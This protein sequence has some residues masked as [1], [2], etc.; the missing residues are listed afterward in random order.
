MHELPT[1]TVTLLFTDI[2]GSTRLLEQ[3]GDGYA[4]AL[5]Q[6]RRLLRA[7]F[8]RHD[9]VEV[10]TQGDAFFVAFGTASDA[11]A[12]A[13]AARMAVAAAGPIRV[14]IGIH[15]GEPTRTDDGYIGMDVNRAARIAAAGHG[16]Q[17]LL[18]QSTRQL[19]DDTD[20]LDLGQHRLKD[21]GALRLFQV[22]DEQFPP[23]KSLGTA[24]LP[25]TATPLFGRQQELADLLRML[26]TERNVLVTI[27]GTGGIGKTRL[28]LEAAAELAPAFADGISFIDLSAVRE[29]ELVEP[30]IVG[31]LGLRGQ[32]VDH[33]RE[34]ELLLVLDNLEQVVQV[35]ANLAALLEASPRLA[36]LAT[37][38]EPLR[39]RAEVTYPLKPLAEAPAVELFR[40]RARMIEPEFDA[41]YERLTEL[42]ERLERI[43]LA[44]EL[45]AA[46]VKVLSPDDLLLR[47]GRRLP[48]LTAGARDAPTRQRTLRATI[49][50]SYELLD[51]DERG[52][53]MNLGVFVGGWTLDAAEQV[54]NADLDVLQ[55]LADKS[56]IRSEDGRFRML[57]TLREYALERLEESDELEPLRMRHTE[58]FLRLGLRAEPELTGAQQHVWLE[59]L[60]I[61]YENLRAALEWSTATQPAD[62]LRLASALV[63][64][65]FNRSLYR[66]G[67]HWLEEVLEGPESQASVARAAA[68]W[69]DGMLWA[70]VG[71]AERAKPR[72]ESGLALA[73]EL[74]APA[75]VARTLEVMG[76]LAFFQND[77]RGAR[78]LLEE[79]AE[80]ARLAGDMWALADAL[81]TL[82]SIYPLQG[83]FD[84]AEKVGAEARAIGREWGD[85][86]GIRM[87]N[88]GLALT[89][90]MRGNLEDARTLSEEG[91]A[92][93]R[94][95]GDLWFVSY[96]LWVL[97]TTATIAGEVRAARVLADESLKIARELEGPLL[98]VCAL[99]A[100]AAVDR[101]EGD[102]ASAQGHLLEALELGRRTI[103][104]DAYL[105]SV[106]RGLGELAVAAG[107][108]DAADA[109]LE[110]S[111]A[112]ARG[113][114]DVWG[115][116][117]AQASQAM[118]AARRGEHDAAVSLA[119]EALAIQERIGDELG[120]ADTSNRIATLTS[121]AR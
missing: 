70:L 21:V 76:L 95:I 36:I 111:I 69:G 25:R 104:P 108:L 49:E 17:I 75:I 119:Q 42:C 121:N 47:L 83:E 99:D 16:G 51:E 33:L 18:S 19:I 6:H 32:L 78:G 57:E 67:L 14:R 60:A 115:S 13:T 3:L 74:D 105:A 1:G 93:C 5:A 9:G 84:L 23:L 98:V 61:D 89:A 82:G 52:L 58:H 71:D 56:L 118:L 40:Q 28:A 41:T 117:R 87:A 15:T 107:D 86:Q 37:S 96:F 102:A 72:L 64:F 100:L 120:A 55:S 109:Y 77:A 45:A 62:G 29:P 79:S 92:I 31:E 46:R 63:L 101:A 44:I 59:R 48:L 112:R 73:R 20:L 90:V 91:L 110:E 80:T 103:V 116:A 85:R 97:A 50:W 7:T 38:R 35:G 113:V 34:R 39:V 65:W 54:C 12:A 53:F 94:E 88:F 30:T 11:L 26:W 114:D 81:G 24:N 2:E 68:F 27:V 106:L 22:G 4:D 8:A 66:E 10:D 43:P